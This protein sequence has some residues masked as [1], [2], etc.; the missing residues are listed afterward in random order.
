MTAETPDGVLDGSLWFDQEPRYGRTQIYVTRDQTAE[1][2]AGGIL[3]AD[4]DV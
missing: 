4:I 2:L 3:A 1:L